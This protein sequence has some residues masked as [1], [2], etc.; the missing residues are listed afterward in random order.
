MAAIKTIAEAIKN[1]DG[2]LARFCLVFALI[3]PSALFCHRVICGH[4]PARQPLPW[5]S[6]T[7]AL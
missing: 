3:G 1:N 2:Q 7:G 5:R 4:R 6:H